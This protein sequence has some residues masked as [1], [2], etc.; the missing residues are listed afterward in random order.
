MAIPVYVLLPTETTEW[1]A[2]PGTS[3][4]APKPV[5]WYLRQAMPEATTQV[6]LLVA[7]EGSEL[8][9]RLDQVVI[10]AQQLGGLAID[11]GSQEPLEAHV[12]ELVARSTSVS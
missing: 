7:G 2:V 10:Q 11:A 3:A 6:G 12:H 1:A 5:R 9:D 8:A 4:Q